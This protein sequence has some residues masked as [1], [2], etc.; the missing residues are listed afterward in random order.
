MAG[1]LDGMRSVVFTKNDY[2]YLVVSKAHDA[3]VWVSP[4]SSMTKL[5]IADELRRLA[6]FVENAR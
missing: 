4:E 1:S 3:E 6:E 5:E 2:D